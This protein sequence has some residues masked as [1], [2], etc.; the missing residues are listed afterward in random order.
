MSDQE[1]KLIAPIVPKKGLLNSIF[2]RAPKYSK[3]TLHYFLGKQKLTTKII[4]DIQKI[5][6]GKTYNEYMETYLFGS[7]IIDTA[8]GSTGLEKIKI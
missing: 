7:K 1:L 3:E 5:I 6:K 2:S 4:L 8:N